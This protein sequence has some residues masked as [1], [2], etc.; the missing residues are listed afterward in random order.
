MAFATYTT[1]TAEDIA[2]GF[3]LDIQHGLTAEM[4]AKANK[5]YGANELEQKKFSVAKI[6]F[7]QFAS[8][9]VYLLGAAAALAFLLGEII[10]GSLIVFFI[11]I[12]TVLGFH[13]E[14]KSERTVEL[15][16]RYVI[17]RARVR[18][19]GKELILP[20]RELVPGDIVIVEAGD[21]IPADLRFF[22]TENLVVNESALTG[23]SVP[24][25]KTGDPLSADS[26][27][28]DRKS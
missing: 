18:R 22:E 5:R 20:A 21:I 4:V 10:D 7:R 2:R 8:P 28:T 16:K 12:N 13:Q 14:Y 6:F 17:A 3:H 9:F 1:S 27:T 11:A 24:V 26:L 15:L 25:T 23:E 19:E